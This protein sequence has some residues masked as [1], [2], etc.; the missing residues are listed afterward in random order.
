MSCS[1][2]FLSFL[3]GCGEGK[4]GDFLFSVGCVSCGSA[5]NAAHKQSD[6]ELLRVIQNPDANMLCEQLA[7]GFIASRVTN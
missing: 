7:F 3:G 4:G 6:V 2:V 1:F 5:C